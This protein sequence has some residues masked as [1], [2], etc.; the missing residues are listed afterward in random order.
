MEKQ[1]DFQLP[2]IGTW[3]Y[4]SALMGI[5]EA[6]KYTYDWIFSN[7]IQIY[8]LRILSENT[9]EY[10]IDFFESLYGDWQYFSHKT[11]PWIDYFKIPRE[12]VLQRWKSAS[13][14]V[15]EQ[16]DN[17]KYV[18]FPL[19]MFY[20]TSHSFSTYHTMLIYGYD[21]KH[22]IF[23]YADNLSNGK[24]DV[25]HITFSELNMAAFSVEHFNE[26]CGR[27]DD[28]DITLLSVRPE[29]NSQ[30]DVTAFNPYALNRKKILH[31]LKAYLL[32]DDYGK[33]YREA[34]SGYVF[35]ISCYDSVRHYIS[36][37]FKA[38]KTIDLR[39]VC[40]LIDHKRLMSKRM[41]Y[42]F[43]SQ[44]ISKDY[45]SSFD[46]ITNS[47]MIVRNMILKENECQSLTTK[48]QQSIENI[49]Y[50]CKCTEER[51]ISE[52]IQSMECA[53]QESVL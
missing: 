11:N 7:Y 15:I 3:S 5:L 13:D 38:K 35:G 19:D 2:V 23:L 49:L 48:N 51:L 36:K 50:S 10:A 33:D 24:Y 20:V 1:L 18:Y 4:Q 31:D 27:S 14:F 44:A 42:L 8:T 22:E 41:E 16:I 25:S 53:G 45:K 12:V 29:S 34:N 46:L 6:H 47:L 52:I 43:Q 28:Y 17:K 21:E 9:R 40:F 32:F 30:F 37:K 26:L 39:T